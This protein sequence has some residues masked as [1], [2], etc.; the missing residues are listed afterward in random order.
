MSGTKRRD[1]KREQLVRAPAGAGMSK[2]L[3]ALALAPA[4]LGFG[5]FQVGWEL[6]QGYFCDVTV[7][8]F[9]VYRKE[10]TCPAFTQDVQAVWPVL[11]FSVFC[12]T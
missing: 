8:A 1:R 5:F 9:Y 6:K 7:D 10:G 4:V 2:L 12:S 3:V 11:K